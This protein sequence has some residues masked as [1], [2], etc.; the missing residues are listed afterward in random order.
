VLE[1]QIDI[2]GVDVEPDEIREGHTG[3]GENSFQVVEA[4]R[5]LRRHVTA[6]LGFPIAAHR[7]LPRIVQRS[8]LPGDD[9][10]LVVAHRHLPPPRI[11]R[12]SLHCHISPFRFIA[13][14][15]VGPAVAIADVLLPSL[16]ANHD[17]ICRVFWYDLA[18][19]R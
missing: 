15:S 4:Q 7:R 1:K 17:T 18:Y 5:Q 9:L 11:D 10:A 8:G 2:G 16:A 14:A 12:R 3:L 6:M 19:A 13:S